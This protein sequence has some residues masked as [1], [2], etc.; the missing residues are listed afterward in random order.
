M[1]TVTDISKAKTSFGKVIQWTEL[2]LAAAF[3]L[4]LI[5][6][7]V[8]LLFH[9]GG[10]W[11]DEA[12]TIN[13]SHLPLT[14]ELWSQLAFDSIPVL[15]FLLLKFWHLIGLG[16]TDFALRTLGFLAGLGILGALWQTAKTL[17]MRL[18]MVSLILF[19]MCP[20]VLAGDSLRAYGLGTA[21]ILLAMSAM[22]RAL[23]H[24]TPRRM[25]ISAILI[26]LSV[27]CLYINA[28]LI[29]AICL[30]A[31][32]VGLYRRDWKMFLFPIGAGVLAALS[33][34]PYLPTFSI[35]K[36]YNVIR[37]GDISLVWIIDR[38]HSAIDPSGVFIALAWSVLALPAVILLAWPL[39]K[40]PPEG[41]DRKK[42]MSIFLL[43]TMTIGVIAYVAFIRI[44][45][46]PT[47]SWYYLPLMALIAIIIDK[48]IDLACTD[49]PPVRVIRM[50][51]SLLIAAFVFSGLWNEAH[52]R[53]T[54]VDML[55]AKLETLA[56]PNDLI[57]VT[58]F[59]YGISFARYYKGSAAWVTL[60]DLSDH[61]THRYDLLKDKMAQNEPVKDV[62]DK[63]TQTLQSGHRV[64]VAGRLNALPPGQI[65]REL[66]PAPF[67]PYGW[68]EGAYQQTWSNMA[69]HALQ[70]SGRTLQRVSVSDDIPV[71]PFENLPLVVIAR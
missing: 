34:L 33:F 71:S 26:L 54:N 1:N 9:S 40:T 12:N 44:L 31:A 25:L 64:W 35:V 62:L 11:R 66:P 42:E 47:Q 41:A 51:A 28:V 23:D 37:T 5:A 43:T 56:G 32:A 46:L 48:G 10:L 14:G 52:V 68:S 24:P 8:V 65:P 39:F 60:P 7:H 16:E 15:W 6:A 57:V 20:T 2:S 61:S 63:I 21:L 19:A 49:R 4:L 53:R 50:A 29:L 70:T 45:A 67:S 36:D 17:G 69:V 58:T 18:P 59:Y 22:W 38:L 3:L 13:V 30:G 55:A 27:Q